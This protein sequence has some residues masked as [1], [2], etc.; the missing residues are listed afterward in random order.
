MGC[1]CITVT[2]SVICPS[3]RNRITQGFIIAMDKYQ[4]YSL[5]IQSTVV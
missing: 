5:P 3:I 4:F 2:D 1:I